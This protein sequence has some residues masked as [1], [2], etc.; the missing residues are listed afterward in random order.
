MGSAQA[1]PRPGEP[2]RPPNMSSAEHEPLLLAAAPP[3]RLLAG[4]LCSCIPHPGMIRF[5]LH[6]R[7][8]LSRHR[9]NEELICHVSFSPAAR[10]CWKHSA[11]IWVPQCTT[12]SQDPLP[13]HLDASCTPQA[14]TESLWV[15]GSPFHSRG[16]GGCR[17]SHPAPAPPFLCPGAPGPAVR[18]RVPAGRSPRTEPSA[19]LIRGCLQPPGPRARTSGK[20]LA[21][22]RAAALRAF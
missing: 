9:T 5:L 13:Q 3:L 19:Q 21:G 14:W 18:A 6:L 17:V 10:G 12:P 16:P 7:D 4:F 15:R 22:T 20:A 11:P 1:V 8:R 2:P